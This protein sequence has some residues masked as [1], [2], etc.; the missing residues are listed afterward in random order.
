VH[1]KAVRLRVDGKL[2]A[3]PPGAPELHQWEQLLRH[4]T[5]GITRAVE[6]P[7]QGTDLLQVTT[8]QVSLLAHLGQSRLEHADA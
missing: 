6:Y 3:I 1:C 5:Q 7:L 8:E 2:V 4:M